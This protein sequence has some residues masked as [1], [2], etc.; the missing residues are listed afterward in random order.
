MS[1][2]NSLANTSP[3]M[4]LKLLPYD[5]QLLSTAVYFPL[6]SH[7]ACEGLKNLRLFGTE[8]EPY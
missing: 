5:H 6:M 3:S 4:A 7:I 8:G 2:N 1:I